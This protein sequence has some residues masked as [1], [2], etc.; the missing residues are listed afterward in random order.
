MKR[1]NKLSAVE[2]QFDK[3]DSVVAGDTRFLAEAVMFNS[4]KL[5][6]L[7]NLLYQVSCDLKHLRKNR[8]QRKLSSWQIFIQAK[9]LEGIHDIKE[10]ARLYKERKG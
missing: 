7:T 2:I 3:I 4:Q 8:K 10:I 1:C 6:E 9:H 5:N